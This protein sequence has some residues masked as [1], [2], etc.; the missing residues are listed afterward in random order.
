M[1]EEELSAMAA[2]L[3]GKLSRVR[4]SFVLQMRTEKVK[5]ACQHVSQLDGYY[6]LS[7]VTGADMGDK[8]SVM[9]H[10]WKGKE[11]VTVEA[12]VPKSDR[13]LPSISSE[14]PSALL[15]EAEVKDLL[16]VRS[17]EHTSELQSRGHLV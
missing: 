8:I 6:H 16:G 4:K 5:D 11:F 10:F 13:H 2:E 17:E 15:Y 3:S 7:T 14:L 1:I 12:D 9:Y